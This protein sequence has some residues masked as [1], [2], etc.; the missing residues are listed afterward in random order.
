M[1]D[2]SYQR[3]NGTESVEMLGELRFLDIVS[4]CDKKIHTDRKSFPCGEVEDKCSE[5]KLN[6]HGKK[7]R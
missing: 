5:R 1:D 4:T 7:E 2:K 3:V 6:F